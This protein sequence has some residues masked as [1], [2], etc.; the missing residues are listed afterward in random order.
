MK[1][2]NMS[3]D[4]LKGYG[5]DHHSRAINKLMPFLTEMPNFVDYIDSRLQLTNVTA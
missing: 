4:F 5:M 2:L 3:L 1:T